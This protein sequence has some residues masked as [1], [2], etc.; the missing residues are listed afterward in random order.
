[1]E[2][3]AA[4]LAF[5]PTA[6]LDDNAERMLAAA[7]GVRTVAASPEAMEAA[8][9]RIAALGGGFSLL[10]IYR[11]AGATPEQVG[12]L[13]ARLQRRFPGLETEILDGGQPEPPLLLAVE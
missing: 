3:I 5:D 13:A 6:S 8:E 1:P 9:E 12:E 11:G 4:A 7:R 10:T 2:G